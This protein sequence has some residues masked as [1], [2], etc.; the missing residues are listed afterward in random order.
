M[1]ATSPDTLAYYDPKRLIA[2][3]FEAAFLPPQRASVAD[4]AAQHRWL[5]NEGGG[6]VG[7]APLHPAASRGRKTAAAWPPPASRCFAL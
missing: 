2:E 1:P 3:V 4:Y 5:S 7:W 6:Y